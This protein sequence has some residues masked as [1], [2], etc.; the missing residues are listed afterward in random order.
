MK[1]I[2]IFFAF[3]AMLS[4]CMY[5]F[6]DDTD[7]S[8][9]ENSQNR[10]LFL[11]SPT[12]GYSKMAKEYIEQTYP[13]VPVWYVDIDKDENRY[14]LLAAKQDYKLGTTIST[15]IICM[16]NQYITGWD[17]NKRNEFDIYVERYSK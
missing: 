16:G 6:K 8:V 7:Y 9:V 15:P 13:N 17:Y 5:D 2:F 12:C 1:K 4:S 11:H 14:Y 10:I 3:L